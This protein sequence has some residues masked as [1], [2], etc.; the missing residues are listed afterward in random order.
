MENNRDI[1]IRSSLKGEISNADN[2]AI[3]AMTGRAQ[4]Y[5]ASENGGNRLKIHLV[6]RNH[7]LANAMRRLPVNDT[8]SN[9]I[10]LYT[11]TREDLCSMKVLGIKPGSM[12]ILT[13]E[14]VTYESNRHIHL[15]IFGAS[16]QAESLAIHTAL[17]SHLP[18]YCRDNNLRTRITWFADSKED[19]LQFRNMYSNLLDHCYRRF[20][21][22]DGGDIRTQT[23][24]PIHTDRQSDFI[25]IEWEFVTGKSNSHITQH[26]LD[27]WGTDKEQILTIA[28]CYDDNC[29][30]L[31]EAISL[32]AVV[33]K[34]SCIL[35]MTDEST[36]IDYLRSSE[37]YSN[38]IPF[39]CREKENEELGDYTLMAQYIN[40]AYSRIR[41]T[42]EEE[43]EH[44]AADI[45]VAMEIPTKEEIEKVWNNSG[46]TTAKRWS[47]IYNAFTLNIKM[48]SLGIPTE[49]WN[50]LFGINDR[51]AKIMT[52]VEHNRWC[53]EELILGYTPTT[54]EQH[55][56]IKNNPALRDILKAGQVHDDL[57]HFSELGADCSG[58]SVTR[59]DL[60]LTR[61][62][63]LI[64]YTYYTSKSL[65]R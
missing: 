47:N 58:F 12:P 38:I 17:T 1:Y 57:R 50:T 51:D 10:E 48:Q 59:Y 11:Y 62:L 61:T 7:L 56:A 13:R 21:D 33:R 9:D 63:P 28:F 39:G 31:N 34:N 49:R 26:K 44:G 32:S 42:T 22:I 54:E 27:R 15:V 2:A 18:N 19:F 36:T 52:Q 16:R 46:L 23:I 64:A 55:K 5:K 4:A 40:F 60:G 45:A 41:S 3:A 25:D 8:L 6:L 35:T 37:E 65:E 20:V 53:I 30:N 14:R 29:R 43:R 24:P